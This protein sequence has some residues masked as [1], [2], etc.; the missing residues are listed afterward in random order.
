[1]CI[2]LC[3]H[4]SLHCLPVY[5]SFALSSLFLPQKCVV[6]F[7]EEKLV[8]FLSK[9]SHFM[10]IYLSNGTREP[11]DVSLPFRAVFI[12]WEFLCR[13]ELIF[14]HQCNKICRLTSKRPYCFDVIYHA[15]KIQRKTVAQTKLKQHAGIEK[16]TV[17][18]WS[19]VFLLYNSSQCLAI[20]NVLALAT[21]S[22][23]VQYG[24]EIFMLE[25]KCYSDS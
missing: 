17:D 21:T 15:L 19:R 23:S 1:M 6:L 14:L 12:L 24:Y 22:C 18:W 5:L 4:S 7:W 20:C 9:F 16:D 25:R 2:V 13:F 11:K 10:Y 3:K 8:P